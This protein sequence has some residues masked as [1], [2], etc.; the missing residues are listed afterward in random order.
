MKNIF[1]IAAKCL[2]DSDIDS[3]LE[4]TR[5]AR[6]LLQ[7]GELQFY[8]L[9]PPQAIAATQFPAR[10]VLCDP[11]TMPR[12]KLTSPAGMLAFYHAIAHIEFVAIYLAWDIIYRFRD[13]PQAFYHDWLQVADEEAQHFT[14]LRTQLLNLGSDYGELPAHSGLWDVAGDTADDLLA[15]LAL[16]PRFMEARGLDVTPGMIEKFSQLGDRQG[17]DILTRILQDEVGHVA[18]G[19]RWFSAVCRERGIDPGKHYRELIATHFKGRQRGPLNR[20]LRKKAGFTDAELDWL[21]QEDYQS[22]KVSKQNL[23]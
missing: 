22:G 20:V 2:Q 13:M 19:S 17:A 6:R 21:E 10:P 7:A 23:H 8:S 1:Q 5:S 4:L 11:R 12:R 18:L 3:K 16:V 9:Q 14:L 15:R